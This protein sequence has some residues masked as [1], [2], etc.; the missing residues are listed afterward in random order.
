MIREELAPAPASSLNVPIGPHRCYTVAR[1]R[2]ADLKAIKNA[3]GGT[4]NDAV[5]TVAAGGLRRLLERRGE[6]MPEHGL[7]AMVPVNLRATDEGTQLGDRV[8]SLFVHLPVYE[9]DPVVARQR[10]ERGRPPQ[11]PTRAG[12]AGALRILISSPTRGAR[13]SLA[14]ATPEERVFA[15]SLLVVAAYWPCA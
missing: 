4:V 10:L 13:W 11:P 5:L 7:R 3:L 9:P 12:C 14:D 1:A 15:V 2:L 8:S 6:E